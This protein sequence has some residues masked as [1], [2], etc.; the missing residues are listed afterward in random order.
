MLGKYFLKNLSDYFNI[1]ILDLYQNVLYWMNLNLFGSSRR[2]SCIDYSTNLQIITLTISD[3]AVPSI[4]W[5]LAYIY[6]GTIPVT[7][8]MSVHGA[9]SQAPDRGLFF[10]G[11]TGFADAG[12][13]SGRILFMYDVSF[14]PIVYFLSSVYVLFCPSKTYFSTF[15]TNTFMFPFGNALL[16]AYWCAQLWTNKFVHA[17]Q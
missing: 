4:I 14:S 6:N 17:L 1:H 16:S 15:L 12:D 10:E 5:P 13:F 7:P 11:T 2:S 9:V 3:P 8:P